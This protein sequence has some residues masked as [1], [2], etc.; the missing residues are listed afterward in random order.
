MFGH[1]RGGTE[2]KSGEQVTRQNLLHI[3]LNIYRHTNLLG[4][5]IESHL[6]KLLRI[7][8][9]VHVFLLA[10]I[11]NVFALSPGLMRPGR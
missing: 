11:N 8:I 4:F 7:P 10:V 6:N 2:I 3:G 5:S 9:L 1:S